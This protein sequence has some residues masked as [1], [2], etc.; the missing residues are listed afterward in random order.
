MQ[1]I[2]SISRSAR[3]LISLVW[4]HL[5]PKGIQESGGEAF[6][7]IQLILGLSYSSP[8]P[9][10]LVKLLVM[11]HNE[12]MYMS[13]QSSQTRFLRRMCLSRQT[14]CLYLIRISY[15]RLARPHDSSHLHQLS[16]KWH[17]QQQYV[18]FPSLA[19]YFTCSWAHLHEAFCVHRLIYISHCDLSDFV[20]HVCAST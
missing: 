5:G 10:D 7:R 8:T 11:N 4:C 15:R 14:N 12:L 13:C 20:R 19:S 2:P 18:Q 17:P 3:C 16:S 1:C 9:S 6:S